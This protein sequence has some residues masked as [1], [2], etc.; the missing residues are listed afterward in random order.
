M[1]LKIDYAYKFK[2]SLKD[3]I[4]FY[5][6]NWNNKILSDE[7][8]YRWQFI[9]SNQAKKDKNIIACNTDDNTIVG[10]MGLNER[11]F[12]LKNKKLKSCEL[13][14]WC[15]RKDLY[16]KGIGPKIL[17]FLKK[18]YDV[19][20]GM[21]ISDDA[22]S[23]YLRKDFQY[24][25]S[26]PRFVKI[27]DFIKV[28]DLSV[29]KNFFPKLLRYKDTQNNINKFYY[30][31]PTNNQFNQVFNFFKK[32]TNCFDRTSSKMN[33]RLKKHP[34]YKYNSFI[35]SSDN[36]FEKNLIIIL[37]IEKYKNLKL[38]R[39]IDFYG[40]NK[41][42]F[43]GLSFI[44]YYSRKHKVNLV[45]FFSTNSLINKYFINHNWISIKDS[46]FF[47]FPHLFEPLEFRKPS[48]T[49]LIYWSKKNLVEISDLSKTYFSKQDCDFDRPA[50]FQND[51]R[52]I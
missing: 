42:Y 27:Y 35:V 29:Y 2:L 5:K 16:N 1:N 6:L 25:D 32:N 44:D 17:D 8:F 12:W 21:S 40:N 41:S 43:S 46:N 9:S 7:T 31:K 19:L 51:K 39:I 3:K 36:K 20:I 48:S 23:V 22:L 28:K 15:V 11:Y 37:R 10:I 33:W 52:K 14:T 24:S 34:K 50:Y 49:S 4:K 47:D 45:D 26:I 13:T 18:K 38:L 30:K